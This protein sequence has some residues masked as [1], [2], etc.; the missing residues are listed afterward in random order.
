MAAILQQ[1]SLCLGVFHTPLPWAAVAQVLPTPFLDPAAILHLTQ[2]PLQVEAA[3]DQ[4]LPEDRQDRA[5]LEQGLLH[6]MGQARGYLVKGPMAAGSQDLTLAVAVVVVLLAEAVWVTQAAL[7]VAAAMDRTRQ[8][9][10][11][12][13]TE[14]LVAVE[15]LAGLQ[16]TVV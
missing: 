2:S 8:L 12:E 1:R 4:L 6:I 11:L 7:V 13:N 10:D 3:A 15:Q 16:G 9:Q 14:P 5:A